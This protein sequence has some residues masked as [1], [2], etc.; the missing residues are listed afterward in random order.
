[1][2]KMCRTVSTRN[3]KLKKKV[4][5]FSPILECPGRKTVNLLKSLTIFL[6][7]KGTAVK[8]MVVRKSTE[9]LQIK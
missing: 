2:Y 4:S 7:T 3:E 5:I 8:Y 1:M 6:F 9:N